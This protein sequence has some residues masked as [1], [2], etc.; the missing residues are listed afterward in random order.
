MS[1]PSRAR[2]GGFVPSLL[3]DDDDS[4]PERRGRRE[5]SIVKMQW[6]REDVSFIFVLEISF[7][8]EPTR[9]NSSASS[10]LRARCPIFSPVRSEINCKSLLTSLTPTS[11]TWLFISLESSRRSVRI[12]L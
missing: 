2:G 5:I 4:K 3:F 11:L 7:L 10:A 8:F 1:L 12:S 9:Y 6:E